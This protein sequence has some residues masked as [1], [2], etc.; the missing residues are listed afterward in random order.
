MDAES[1]WERSN[2]MKDFL[3]DNKNLITVAVTF[4]GTGAYIWGYVTGISAENII[5]AVISGLFGMGT[6]AALTKLAEKE[7]PKL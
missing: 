1:A 5:T 2:A 4:L 6:G 7:P 3:C